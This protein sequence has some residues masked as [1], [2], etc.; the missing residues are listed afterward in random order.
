MYGRKVAGRELNFEP[1]GALLEASLVMRDRETDSW[2]SIMSSDSIGG[3]LEGTDLE[4][5]PLGEKVQWKDWRAR[6]PDTLVLS[7]DGVEHER[8]NPYDNYFSSDGTFRGLHVDD[9]RLPP[10]EPIY[11]FFHDASA[12]AI[13][14]ARFE[15]GRLFELGGAAGKHLLV[16]RPPG[17]SVFASSAAWF[18]DAEAAQ[19]KEVEA[20]LAAAR[21]GSEGFDPVGGFDT[22]WYTWVAVNPQ[23]RLLAG[24]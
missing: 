18:V 19:G 15:G 10:K 3:E 4:E 9:D 24:R 8:N 20:L 12:F 21:R 22:Y 6:H 23:S 7:V 5:L 16:H 13:A 14:H 1:S 11:A 2:W 17:A